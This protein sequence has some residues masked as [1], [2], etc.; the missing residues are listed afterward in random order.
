[1]VIIIKV[2]KDEFFRET[3][4]RLCGHLDIREALRDCSEYVRRFV[5]LSRMYLQVF[6]PNLTLLRVVSSVVGEVQESP[7]AASMTH[8]V[9]RLW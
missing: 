6:D 1:V 4:L 2:D 7:P 9:Y 8:F 3:T 5:P